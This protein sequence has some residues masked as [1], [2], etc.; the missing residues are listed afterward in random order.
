MGGKSSRESSGRRYS[1]RGAASSSSWDNNSYG[2]PPQSPYHM[3]Q[4]DP[5]YTPQHRFTPSSSFNY[6]PQTPQRRVDRKYS[7]IEDNYKTLDQVK[8]CFD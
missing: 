2:Y 3:P 7:K 6:R 5:Y 4:P 1:S 8:T